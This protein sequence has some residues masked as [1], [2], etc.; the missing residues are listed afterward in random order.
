MQ[1]MPIDTQSLSSGLQDVPPQAH[2]NSTQ[3]RCCPAR[4]SE[5]SSVDQVPECTPEPPSEHIK[6]FILALLPTLK[7]VL[8]SVAKSKSDS[9]LARP[10]QTMDTHPI[11]APNDR[12]KESCCS[13][14]HYHDYS[15]SHS[16]CNRYEPHD[17]P[18]EKLRKTSKPAMS[19]SQIQRSGIDAQ[20]TQKV[21]SSITN[22]SRSQIR[23]A[24]DYGYRAGPNAF[25]TSCPSYRRPKVRMLRR[26]HFPS[27][28]T[29]LCDQKS[30]VEHRSEQTRV[31]SRYSQVC[32]GSY[33]RT[34]H[35]NWMHLRST[36]RVS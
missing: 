15:H 35:Q 20:Y 6:E 36:Y 25:R 3:G 12:S 7:M 18:S 9:K 1:T 13:G 2:L 5:S 34:E 16:S 14:G 24:R 11:C 32:L 28:Q 21:Q 23:T 31:R 17:I 22:R 27:R 4:L 10:I 19:K 8:R 29:Y 30:P 33:W 26:R